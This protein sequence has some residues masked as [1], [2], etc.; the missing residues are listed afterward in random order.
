M[1]VARETMALRATETKR[2]DTP[3]H[4][5]LM[6]V[7]ATCLDGDTNITLEAM[8]ASHK[9]DYFVRTSDPDV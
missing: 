3:N 6:G 5:R 9:H 8:R 7:M 2:N 1:Q 4:P